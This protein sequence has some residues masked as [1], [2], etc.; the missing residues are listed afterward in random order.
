MFFTLKGRRSTTRA[1]GFRMSTT[2]TIRL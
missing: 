1:V 2:R